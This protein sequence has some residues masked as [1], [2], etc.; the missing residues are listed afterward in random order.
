MK[1]GDAVSL[2]LGPAMAALGA[3]IPMVSGR[4]LGH[5]G[6]TLDKLESIPG[7][8]TEVGE[9]AFRGIVAEAGCAMVAASKRIAPADRRLYA[10]RD[11]TSTV[12]SID[13]I[14]ASILSKK[15]ASG[16][17]NLVMDVKAGSG[18][19]MKTLP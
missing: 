16:V 3:Y 4:G 6:G 1:Q 7:L 5:T 14:T 12:E 8:T 10:V 2:L 17:H 18:A 19:F 15:L 13:L 9:D 11:I